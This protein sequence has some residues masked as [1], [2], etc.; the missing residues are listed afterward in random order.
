MY[1]CSGFEYVQPPGSRGMAV[2]RSQFIFFSS[3]VWAPQCPLNPFSYDQV[4]GVPVDSEQS[5]RA[6][7]SGSIPKG[8]NCL[9]RLG[10]HQ[11]IG[12]CRGVLVVCRLL[13]PG[14]KV[15]CTDGLLR[16]L[17]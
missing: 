3:Q 15:R 6:S 4:A 16:L 10:L 2:G 12:T 11:W 7:L 14:G 17:A 1:L 13:K 8:L 9:L 5:A